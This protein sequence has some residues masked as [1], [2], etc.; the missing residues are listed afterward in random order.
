MI[1]LYILASMAS[2]YMIAAM[3]YL[4]MTRTIGTPFKDALVQHEKLHDLYLESS[5]R[6]RAIYRTGWT[7]GASVVCLLFV[8]KYLYQ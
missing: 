8:V 6:R 3:Y 1:Y 7:V 2:M 5:A 4:L